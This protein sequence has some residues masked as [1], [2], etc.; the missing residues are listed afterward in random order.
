LSAYTGE[1]HFL[2][3]GGLHPENVGEAIRAM[4]SHEKFAGVDVSSGIEKEKGRK[5]PA[6]MMAFAERARAAWES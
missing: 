1:R 2:L 4:R 6:L 5:D 3:A